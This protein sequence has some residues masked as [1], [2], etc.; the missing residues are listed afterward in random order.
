VLGIGG[1]ARP[2]TPATAEGFFR[3]GFYGIGPVAGNGA[4]ATDPRGLA[5]HL[6]SLL[7]AAPRER[8]ALG[9]L[10]RDV[11][12][13]RYSLRAA[14]DRLEAVY[15]DA[16]ATRPSHR[17]RLAEAARTLAYRTGSELVPERAKVRARRV[18]R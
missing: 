18:L 13:E 3:A 4:E 8:R 10:C 2:F 15:A 1:F 14:A 17:R 16:L 7:E 11:V 6:R 9:T 12:L 5:G